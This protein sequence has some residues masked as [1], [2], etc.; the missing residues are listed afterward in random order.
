MILNSQAVNI[1]QGYKPMTEWSIEGDWFDGQWKASDLGAAYD[2]YKAEVTFQGPEALIQT[3]ENTINTYRNTTMSMTC[4][5]G[6]EIFGAEVDYTS[7][8]SVVPADIGPVERVNMAL[9]SLK[10]EFRLSGTPSFKSLSP[11][12]SALTLRDIKYTANSTWDRKV[13][14]TLDNSV[15]IRNSEGNQ[16]IFEAEFVQR[17]D[18]M[19]NIR[20][21]ILNNARANDFSFPLSIDYPF[22]Y[23]A[24]TG[25]FT[26][27]IVD[28]EDLGRFR[29]SEWGLRIK[30][31]RVYT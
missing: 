22:G 29:Y 13:N 24:G 25:P 7:A 1:W 6:E 14:A 21:Y 20:R 17:Q 11:S 26:V 23:R 19:A 8:L 28:W 5:E 9:Y 15:F 30:F 18:D 27:T 2:V 3:V 31:A 10:V 16:G 12:L 4:E